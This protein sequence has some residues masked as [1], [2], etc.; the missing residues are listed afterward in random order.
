MEPTL[1][2]L[3]RPLPRYTTRQRYRSLAH[4]WCRTRLFRASFANRA[5][6]CLALGRSC[7]QHIVVQPPSRRCSRHWT[8]V[9]ILQSSLTFWDNLALAR[10][11]RRREFSANHAVYVLISFYPY[12][13]RPPNAVLPS[14]ETPSTMPLVGDPLP[15]ASASPRCPLLSLPLEIRCQIYE[16]CVAASTFYTLSDVLQLQQT[17]RTIYEESTAVFDNHSHL[18]P[19][20]NRLYEFLR[21]IGRA[22]RREIRRLT[23]QYQVDS[24]SAMGQAKED[25]IALVRRTFKLMKRE[26][27]MLTE[28][29]VWVWEDAIKRDMGLSWNEDY[30]YKYRWAKQDSLR[31]AAG[32]L[33]LKRLRG[34]T[35]MWWVPYVDEELSQDAMEVLGECRYW[36]MLPR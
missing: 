29:W 32:L 12:S 5:V 23:F 22:R 8:L 33:E 30:L 21:K 36:M 11:D 13:F 14:R 6:Y 17:C 9:S 31:T 7:D 1:Y 26:C 34:L 15:H 4:P 16:A 20:I 27:R 35:T 3:L 10:L 24:R 28:L 18:F 25:D 2:M 19:S